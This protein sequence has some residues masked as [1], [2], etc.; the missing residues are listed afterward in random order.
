MIEG[1]V[2]DVVFMDFSKGFDMVCHGRLVQKV[3]SH[4]TGGSV[5]AP[6]LF[7]ININDLEEN[8][9]GLIS[10]SA[11]NTKIGAVADSEEAYQRRQQDIDLLE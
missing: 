6:L 5:L 9:A 7:V 11:D 8:V 3:K 10:K 2:V 4:G 1:K